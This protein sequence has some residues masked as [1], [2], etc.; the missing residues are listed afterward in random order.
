VIQEGLRVAY[1]ITIRQSRTARDQALVYKD[2]VIPA[3]VSPFLEGP[4]TEDP[5]QVC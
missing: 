4:D 2:W 3:G 1:G 5:G